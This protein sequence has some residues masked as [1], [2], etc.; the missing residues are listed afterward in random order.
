MVLLSCFATAHADDTLPNIVFILADDMGYGD[1]Q[2]LNPD[3][4]KIATPAMDRLAGEGMIFTDAHTTSSVCTPTRYGILTGRYNWR[5]HLQKS[6]LFGFDK[7][8]IDENRL[9]V[10]GFLKN[11]GYNTAAIGKWHLGLDLPTTDGEPIKGNNPANIDWDQPVKNGPVTRGF[12]YYFGISASLDMPPYIYIENDRFVGKGTATKAF[13]RKGPAEPDFEAIDVLPMIG[14][15]A[16]EFIGKQDASKP[17]FAY[18]P[19]TSPHTPILPSKQWQGKS[20]LGKY[21]DFVMQT[22][23]VIGEIVAAIDKAGLAD[24]TLVIVTS[25]NG[26]SKA[27][28]IKELEAMGHFPSGNLRGSKADL[29]DGGH[30][31]PFI[32]RWPGKVKPGSVSDQLICQADLMATA[33]D[34]IGGTVPGGAGEDSV[35]FKP[36]L[37]GQPIVSTRA[38]LIHHSIGGHFA[39]RQGKWKLLLAKGSGGWS[40]PNERQAKDRTEA[41]L[42]DME[43][44]LGETNNLYESEPEVAERLL[45]QLTSDVERGRS[46]DGP[47][48]ANDVDEIN[49]WK[50][51]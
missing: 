28:G 20:S 48:S 3:R 36:A 26:C 19:F 1:V 18:I 32:V 21:G 33:A 24:N 13:N 51:R 45:K 30:R 31:V 35:S 38:G 12:D 22:D 4:G 42:Y 29:W 6:V 5:T 41:Q 7:P 39:Y 10:A 14:K 44:D 50:S 46:T 37:S 15:K 40:S 2:C 9:T 47:A 11:N 34:I 25:D 23:A 8:L 43:S 27:A 49:L 16:A 17:F